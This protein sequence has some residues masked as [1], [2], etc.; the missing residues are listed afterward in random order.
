M[1]GREVPAVLKAQG[2]TDHQLVPAGLREGGA[3]IRELII[4]E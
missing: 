4:V 3:G 2:L 1:H